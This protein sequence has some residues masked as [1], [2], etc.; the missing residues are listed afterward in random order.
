M[1]FYI[2]VHSIPLEAILSNVDEF[3][4]GL[5]NGQYPGIKE[6]VGELGMN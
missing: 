1:V 2:D 3:S 6:I 4:K 5:I